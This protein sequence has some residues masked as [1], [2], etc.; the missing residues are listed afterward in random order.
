MIFG[1]WGR[2]YGETW[3]DP[4]TVV[5]C[6]DVMTTVDQRILRVGVEVDGQILWYEG[7][8][9][10]A[11]GSRAVTDTQNTVNAE[12][13]NLSRDVRNYLLTETSPFNAN[14]TPKRLYVEAGR[15]STGV[16]QVFVGDI[17]SASPTQ[18]PDIG[19]K[20][21]AQTG[22]FKKGALVARSGQAKDKLSVIAQQVADDLE[23][24]LIFEADDRFIANWTFS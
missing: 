5:W 14:R 10:T 18:P 24:D 7:L 23:N 15:V 9:I 19:L 22:A 4:E 2:Y 12:I 8:R 1:R 11:K 13:S 16:A 20:L 6:G 17:V 3:T 21:K